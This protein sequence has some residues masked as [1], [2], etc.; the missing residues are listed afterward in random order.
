[1]GER[2]DGLFARPAFVRYFSAVAVGALG[3]ALTAVALPVLVVDVLDASP[4]EVGLVSAAQFVPYALLGLFAGVYVDR[5]RRQRVLV[6]ASIGR[7]VSLGLIPVLWMAGALELWVLIALLLLF[8]SFAV[9][10]FAATQSLLPQIVERRALL[11][12]NARLDQ[13]EA[14][15]QTAG[16]ALGGALV[17]LL[18]APLAL[19]VDTVTYIAD[20]VLIA[21]ARITE[22]IDRTRAKRSLRRE[23]AE[24][25]RWIYRHATLAPLAWSTH[26]WFF[27]NAAALTVLAV[28]AL[29]SLELGPFAYGLLFATGG[30]ATLLG[31]S[32][33]AVVGGRIGAGPA[34]IAARGLYPIAWLAIALLPSG[35]ADP[36]ALA[37]LFGAFALQGLAAGVENA[38]EMSYWQ[39]VTPD[40]LLGRTNGTRRSANRTMAVV[41]ALAGGAA[42]SV[43]ELNAVLL[44]VAAIFALAFLIALAS[45]LRTA[46][47]D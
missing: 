4:F 37:L 5:W 24:G 12:A 30:A 18:G 38:N 45:P 14:A 7:A 17:G 11:A 32:L 44:G 1:M 3:T 2:E 26:V 9:F 20:A 43:F 47:A 19:A 42:A 21:G 6:W 40:A 33:A 15:A 13:A 35:D 31:A 16:P 10:G 25:V 29:R 39:T 8:G 36:V 34:I 23:V 22:T 28:F 46:R 41:G 27:A